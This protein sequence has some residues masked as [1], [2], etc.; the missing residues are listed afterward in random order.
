LA[1]VAPERARSLPPG[2]LEVR[3]EGVSFRYHD[4]DADAGPNLEGIDLTVPA[5]HHLGLLGRT[6]S[7]K[8]TLTRLLFRFYD[9]SEGRLWLSGVDARDVPLAELRRRVGM[10]TQEVQLFQASVRDNLTFFDPEVPDGRL[11]EVLHEVG[12]GP[13]F[14]ALPDG[15]ST[16]V[17]A[18]GA[19]LSAGEAQLLALARVFL[20]DPGLVLLD[21][22]SS[23]LDPVT[24]R[25]LERA[26][27]RLLQGRTAVIIAH[28][29]ETVERVDAV[30][31][32]ADAHLI[33]HGRRAALAADPTSRYARLRHAA[34]GAARGAA[35]PDGDD[36][37]KELA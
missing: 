37:L 24:E 13:W 35:R 14:G 20:K 21:E 27:E 11:I 7:G 25:R 19:N 36:L 33:E 9:P 8:T 26:L 23:R 16:P 29:L 32:L 30:A 15:L 3:F 17:R 2:P 22:P 31:V 6:G 12:L 4:A 10:V 5:G 34:R 28:R 1:V 18:G